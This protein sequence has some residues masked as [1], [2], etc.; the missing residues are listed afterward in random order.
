LIKVRKAGEHRYLS[1]DLTKR[2]LGVRSMIH[3][4]VK[5][6]VH[7]KA[8]RKAKLTTGKAAGMKCHYLAFFRR[9]YGEKLT[10]LF[11]HLCYY[12]LFSV[13]GG[14]L[15]EAPRLGLEGPSRPEGD[16]KATS[17]AIYQQ[18]ERGARVGTPIDRIGK[19]TTK[20]QAIY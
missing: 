12:L 11:D 10:F 2:G 18:Q 8:F 15:P 3:Q 7:R 5:G 17:E 1:A 6:V 9:I 13:R 4:Q 14:N 16:N 20:Q 19:E